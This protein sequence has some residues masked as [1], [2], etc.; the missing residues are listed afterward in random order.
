MGGGG[1]RWGGG[2]LV[3]VG[4]LHVQRVSAQEGLGVQGHLD[5]GGV[6]DGVTDQH[7]VGHRGPGGGRLH[8]RG[9]FKHAHMARA[10]EHLW[11]KSGRER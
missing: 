8:L 3:A 10:L 11:R 1:V 2:P 5:V 4:E 9:G 7:Q 6:R